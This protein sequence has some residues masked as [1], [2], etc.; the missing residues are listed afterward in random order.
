MPG[1]VRVER[2][3]RDPSR[4]RGRVPLSKRAGPGHPEFRDPNSPRLSTLEQGLAD[5]LLAALS[6]IP[7]QSTLDALV[8]GDLTGYADRVRATL[9]DADEAIQAALMA[10]VVASGEVAAL[11]LGKELAA[12]FR[13]VGKADAPLPSEVAMRFRFDKFDPRATNW[14]RNES[15][16]LIT[17]MVASE[18]AAMRVVLDA[19]MSAR[20]NVGQMG[21]AIMSQLRNV[22]PSAG[23]SE[24][25]NTLGSNLNGLTARYE[26]AVVNRVNTVAADLADRGI[27]GTKALEQMRKEGD[28]YAER[29]RRARSKTIARTERMRAHNTARQLS[30]EQAIDS[31]LA[32]REFARKEWRTGPFD[33]CPICVPMMGQQVKVSDG[34][35]LPNGSQVV[36]P[37]A[38]PN[39][40]CSMVMVSDARLYEPP[41]RLGTGEP[42]DPF[43]VPQRTPSATGREFGQRPLPRNVP[44]P[45][46]VSMP[47]PSTPAAQPATPAVRYGP[48]PNGQRT[49]RDAI[50][51]PEA[52][53]GELLKRRQSID[54]LIDKIDDIH[55]LPDDGM[56]AT[57][58][59]FGGKNQGKGGHFTPGT[60]GPKPRRKKGMT[61]DEW[62]DV[63]NEYNARPVTPEIMIAKTREEFIGQGMSDFIHELGHRLDWDTSNYVSRRAWSSPEARSLMS[64]RGPQWVEHL[65]EIVDDEIRDFLELGKIVREAESVKTYLKGASV[66]HR[67]YFTSIEEVWARAYNQYIAE[68]VADPRVVSYMDRMKKI[69][70]QFSDDEFDNVR[71]IVDRILRRRGLMRELDDIADIAAVEIIETPAATV[72]TP[73]SSPPPAATPSTFVRPTLNPPRA[74][75]DEL[76]DEVADIAADL[77][78][79]HGYAWDIKRGNPAFVRLAERTGFDAKPT[80]VADADWQAVIDDGWVPMYRGINGDSADDV[81][82]YV[83]EFIEGEF[84]FGGSGMFG[85]GTYTTDIRETAESYARHAHGIGQQ[86]GERAAGEV[87]ELALHPDAKVIDVDDINREVME[88]IEE[89]RRWENSVSQFT[90]RQQVDADGYTF[91]VAVPYEELPVDIQRQVDRFNAMYQMAEDDPGRFAL[92]RGYDA[93]RIN[94]PKVSYSEP[95]LPDTFYAVLNRGALAVRR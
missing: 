37:P 32:S 80:I 40:R 64:R 3:S 57:S 20:Q 46:P 36:S 73:A 86:Q 38:H 39:C 8:S 1:S 52:Q 56:A 24:F 95:E 14:V 22:S 68:I 62:R 34:F 31:G 74:T 82:R 94:R 42:G 9:V 81:A 85:S 54:E 28:R 66:G 33:V 44:Q 13:A 90:R 93:I 6:R 69:G 50:D 77:V 4:R 19:S 5:V 27:T 29:L 67:Q 63:V 87:I 15:S 2:Y 47:T 79:K 21:S 18:Q 49:V 88:F 83:S 60:R 55:G 76:F 58:L 65:D 41:S 84:E 72:L 75:Y 70:Y 43:R 17:N 7:R 61:F 30:F 45:P 91:E 10:Q 23:V 53:K 35:T 25:A 89:R 11:E 26:T 78:D 12:G 16:T 51:L 71:A 59:K 48:G 92:M